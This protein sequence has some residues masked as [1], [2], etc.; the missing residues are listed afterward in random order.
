M[1]MKRVFT[2]LMSMFLV[3]RVFAV[4]PLPVSAGE[5]LLF[6]WRDSTREKESWTGRAR[7]AENVEIRRDRPRRE[8]MGRESWTIAEFLS[9][10]G[11]VWDGGER[12]GPRG[13]T[14][15]ANL[16]RWVTLTPDVGVEWRSNGGWGVVV[17][18]TWTSWSR[19]GRRYALWCVSPG[20][21][22]YLPG[23]WH[24][25]VFGQGGEFNYK[26]GKT[27]RQGDYLGGGVAGGRR[28]WLGRRWSLDVE[29]GAGY[30]RGKYEKYRLIHDT[31]VRG[32]EVKKGYWGVNRF[33]INLEFKI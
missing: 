27:G 7:R 14:L 10:G 9:R 16:A 25:G 26:P 21:R 8:A 28:R 2:L 18:G 4:L 3:T 6:S 1:L 31:R 15:R 13:F 30:T 22:Y 19:G 20:V 32:R 33:G 17:N 11:E 29:V 23:G 5:E 12:L 24:V